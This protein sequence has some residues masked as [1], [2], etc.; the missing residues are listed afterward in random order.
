MK[1]ILFLGHT[2]PEPTTTAAGS[3]TLQLLSLFSEKKDEVTFATTAH[4][5]DFSDETTAAN[6]R[7]I[8]I[9]SAS[10]DTFVSDLKPDVVLYDR[11]ITEEQLGWRVR[12]Q[13]PDAL[14]VLDTQDLHFLRKAREEAVKNNSPVTEAFL[15]TE[16]AKRELAAILRCDLSLI[17]SQ[18]EMQLLQET[19][20]VDASVLHYLP[21]LLDSFSTQKP[22][23]NQRSH[24]FT[25]GNFLHKPNL[26]SVIWLKQHIWTAIKKQLPQAELHIYGAY[27]PQH[28]QAFHN[29]KE[30]FIIKGWVSNVADVMQKHSICLTPL[31]F[32]AGLKGKIMDAMQHGV[33]VVTTAIGAE[34]IAGEL[35]FCGAVA[36]GVDELVVASVTLYTQQEKWKQVQQNGY[37]ILETRFSKHLFA[38]E[39]YDTIE[40]MHTNLSHHRNHHFLGQILNHHSLQSTKFLSKWIEEKNKG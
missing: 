22:D 13:C 6:F 18:F 21:F 16:T 26:D 27:A 33:P 1:K 15:F 12:E 20:K 28:I 11:F 5:T 3:R 23:F 17:I 30:G 37:K 14:Q 2:L 34:G 29:P 36:H 8:E 9:N 24:F 25:M 10:F 32:G 31:R 7:S 40:R 19:F 4:K 38:E 35:P 39:L